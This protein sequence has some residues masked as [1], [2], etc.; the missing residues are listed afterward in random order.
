MVPVGQLMHDHHCL[1]QDKTQLGFTT[2]PHKSYLLIWPEGREGTQGGEP[3]EQGNTWKDGWTDG[4]SNLF[5]PGLV[6]PAPSHCSL[7]VRNT[8]IE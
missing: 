4:L 8:L 1:C 3:R 5:Y 2:M 7:L 6:P